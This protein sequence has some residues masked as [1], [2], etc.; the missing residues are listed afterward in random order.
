M[1]LYHQLS[2]P[3]ITSFKGLLRQKIIRNYEFLEKY[4][5]LTEAVFGPDVPTLEG[6]STRPKPRKVVDNEV[7]IPGEFV[8]KDRNFELAI[9][10]MCINNETILTTIDR[11][12]MFKSCVL[13]RLRDNEDICSGLDGILRH[14]NKGSHTIIKIHADGEFESLLLWIKDDLE[15]DLNFVTPDEHMGNIERLNCTIK[16]EFRTRYYRLPSPAV[17]RMP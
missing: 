12:I 11:S 2:A 7:E 10:I 3:S 16:E 5:E 8:T 4:I 6:K 1:W 15:I 17:P 9:D 14:Y 13:L